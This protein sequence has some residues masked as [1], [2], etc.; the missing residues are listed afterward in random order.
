MSTATATALRLAAFLCY[1][2]VLGA[3]ALLTWQCAFLLAR[4]Q[5]AG[6][7]GAAYAGAAY[8]LGRRAARVVR[9]DAARPWLDLL[10]LLAADALL[11]VIWVHGL[12]V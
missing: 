7:F 11:G 9:G 1:L 3:L 6:A 10:L 4:A 2:P 12:T 8:L 5:G